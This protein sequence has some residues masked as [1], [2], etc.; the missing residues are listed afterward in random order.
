MSGGLAIGIP[1]Q[2][3]GLE[4][5]WK[6]FG[7]LPWADLFRPAVKLAQHGFPV[8][9]AVARAIRNNKEIILSG[10]FPSLK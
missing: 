1:G 8:S 7:V 5:A 3:R 4:M 9:A 2:L 6:R 10:N